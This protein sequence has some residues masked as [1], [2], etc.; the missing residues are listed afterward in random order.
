MVCSELISGCRWP[1]VKK[2]KPHLLLFWTNLVI[3]L[4]PKA[5]VLFYV[6][7]VPI[8]W[9]VPNPWDVGSDA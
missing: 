1:P 8:T 2:K 4:G 6:L 7:A 9:G 5:Y 3:N